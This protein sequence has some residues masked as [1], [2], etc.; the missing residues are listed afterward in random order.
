MT[1]TNLKTYT[2][3]EMANKYDQD[4]VMFL[5]PIYTFTYRSKRYLVF[6]QI[7]ERV[8]CD[9]CKSFFGG[10]IIVHIDGIWKIKRA[11]I[12]G[13]CGHF[14]GGHGFAKS[15]YVQASNDIEESK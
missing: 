11:K 12:E 2:T 8:F 6:I 3:E 14:T 1:R 4:L 15:T 9:L 7:E 5:V 13:L 10:K